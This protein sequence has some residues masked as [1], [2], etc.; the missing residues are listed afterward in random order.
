[1][2]PGGLL[3][4]SGLLVSNKNIGV[5]LQRNESLVFYSLAQRISSLAG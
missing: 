2:V 5:R 3:Q 4:V 1:M